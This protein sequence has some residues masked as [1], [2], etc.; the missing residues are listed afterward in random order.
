MGDIFELGTLELL[1]SMVEAVFR[2]LDVDEVYPF[3]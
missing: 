3:A 1:N 2:N